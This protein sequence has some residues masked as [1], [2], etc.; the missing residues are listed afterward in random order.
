MTL[1]EGLGLIAAVGHIGSPLVCRRVAAGERAHFSVERG[2][3]RDG[4]GPRGL[5]TGVDCSMEDCARGWAR[6]G[7]DNHRWILAVM[8]HSTSAR[9]LLPTPGTESQ[10]GG[11]RDGQSL[12]GA[13]GGRAR[14][15]SHHAIAFVSESICPNLLLQSLLGFSGQSHLPLFCRL[16]RVLAGVAGGNSGS[17]GQ[18]TNRPTPAGRACRNDVFPIIS[19]PELG[20]VALIA[21]PGRQGG[22]QKGGHTV[23]GGSPPDRGGSLSQK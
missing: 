21:A 10:M 15:T 23:D 22:A 5:L 12:R 16:F 1:R 20:V 19:I 18:R 11:L 14:G 7:I 17:P 9:V 3:H 6:L 13:Q 8:A 2:G 4:K